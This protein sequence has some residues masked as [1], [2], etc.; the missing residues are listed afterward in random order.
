M[1][2]R[3]VSSLYFQVLLAITLGVILG[4]IYPDLGAD[5]K[6][7][8]DGSRIQLRSATLAYAA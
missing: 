6:P 3:I 4:H 7:L 5:M 1:Q 8:G 2:K